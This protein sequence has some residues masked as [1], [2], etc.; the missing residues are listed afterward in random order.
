MLMLNQNKSKEKSPLKKGFKHNLNNQLLMNNNT[1]NLNEIQLKSRRELLEQSKLSLRPKHTAFRSSDL[2]P[3]VSATAVCIECGSQ[4]ESD[5][6]FLQSIKVCRKCLA[7][8]ARIEAAL[9]ERAK[10][11]TQRREMSEKLAGGIKQ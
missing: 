6:D 10:R 11:K 1:R 5:N 3:Q 4:L 9:D 2:L 7:Q 8:H